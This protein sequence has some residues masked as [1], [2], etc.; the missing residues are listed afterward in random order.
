M[1]LRGVTT[2][3]REFPGDL[4]YHA[5]NR[6]IEGVRLFEDDAEYV[7]FLRVLAW[8][9][10]RTGTRLLGYCLMPT[11]W[12]LVVW[13]RDDDEL[14]RFLSLASSLHGRS[15]RELRGTPG[16]GAVYQ[17]RFK[18]SPVKDDQHLLTLL[19]YV[20][21]NPVRAGLVASASEWPFSSLTQRAGTSVMIAPR[22]SPWPVEARGD[23]SAW[24]DA[25]QTAAELEA[26]RKCLRAGESLGP[27]GWAA[28]VDARRGRIK[29]PRGRPPRR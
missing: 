12:H 15:L 3:V 10:R 23:W 5:Y 27:A 13:P 11:H 9:Q 6:A 22:L 19:R 26:L 21:R 18:A 7:V 16:R 20:E 25:A 4:I 24:V 2:A 17:D 29:R 8:A 14:R 28:A 1:I